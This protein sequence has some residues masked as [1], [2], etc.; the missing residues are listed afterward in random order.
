MSVFIPSV[1]E[2]IEPEVNFR[3]IRKGGSIYVPLQRERELGA[4]WL[5]FAPKSRYIGT[6][7]V[8]TMVITTGRRQRVSRNDV[9]FCALGL[10]IPEQSVDHGLVRQV[11]RMVNDQPD[12]SVETVRRAINLALKS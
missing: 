8:I 10:G 3:A 9:I 11:Q 4:Y 6:E 2:V 12:S 7:G 1:V 5:S